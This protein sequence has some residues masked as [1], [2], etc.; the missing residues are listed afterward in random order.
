MKQTIMILALLLSS[1]GALAQ[2][3]AP[4]PSPSAPMA[5]AR[6]SAQ[7][8]QLVRFELTINDRGGAKPVTKTLSLTMASG[9]EVGSIRTGAPV[10]GIIV[11]R[12]INTDKE[13]RI[14]QIPPATLV[15]QLNFDVRSVIVYDDQ[16][17]RANISVEYQPM[18][19]DGKTPPPTVRA[20]STSVFENGKKAVLLEA[21]DP[22]SDRRTTIEIVATV[23]K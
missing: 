18:P 7:R 10:P 15:L 4:A 22:V 17:V 8:P 20:S 13:G 2:Q 5:V 6:L 16:S 9:N 11:E 1:G 12:G 19:T 23:L 21:A 3:P 14:Q